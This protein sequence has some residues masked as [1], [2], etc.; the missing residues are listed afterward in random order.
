MTSD[1]KQFVYLVLTIL[2]AVSTWYFNIQFMMANGS[3][4]DD[5]IA[6][7]TANDAARSIAVDIVV[8]GLAFLFWSFLEAKRLGMTNWWLYPILSGCIAIAFA[9]PLFLYMRERKLV[10]LAESLPSEQ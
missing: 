2:G 7:A 8:F 10:E 6:G 5:F 1:K 9:A 4:L 3:G